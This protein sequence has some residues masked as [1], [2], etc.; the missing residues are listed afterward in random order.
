MRTCAGGCA[1]ILGHRQGLLTEAPRALRPYLSD[2][3][4]PL[5]GRTPW[6]WCGRRTV[7]EVSQVLALCACATRRRGRAARRQHQLLR[8][9]DAGCE[10]PQLVLALERMQPHPQA[11]MPPTTPSIAEAGCVLARCSRRR[12][13]VERLFPAEPRLGG[14]L[15]DRRQ[16]LHQRRRHR[17]LRYGMMRDLVLGLEV[18]LADGRVLECARSVCARTTPATTYGTFSSA[19]KAR[20][21]SSLPRASSCFRSSAPRATALVARAPTCARRSTLLARCA[22]PAATASGPSSS[23]RDRP[24]S[25]RAAHQRRQRSARH[26]ARLVCAV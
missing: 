24:G 23:S 4:R 12:P 10:W 2:H 15:P 13:R 1:R 25:H 3:R 7:A 5:P 14:Q 21:G 16:S 19:P 8:R 11:S 22:P 17:V 18:V 9:R 20:S 6:P 26:A